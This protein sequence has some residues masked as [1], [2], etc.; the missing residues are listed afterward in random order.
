MSLVEGRRVVVS[1]K[2]AG[3]SRQTAETKLREAG[4]LVQSA[5]GK[6]TDVL[7]IGEKVG[8]TKL[9]KAKELG[10][11]VV[12]WEQAFGNYAPAAGI[13]VTVITDE[14]V[15]EGVMRPG[16]TLSSWV[17]PPRAPLPKVKQWAPMLCSPGEL[18][19]GPG[20]V[21]EM[22]WDGIRG[23]ATIEGGEV[24]LQSRS[25]KT[26]LTERY[27]VI[28]GE[29]A[30]L[31][32]CVLDGELVDGKYFVFDLLSHE[33][34]AVTHLPLMERRAILET[35]F[36]P[37]VF[38]IG[39]SPAFDDGLALLSH[40]TENGLEGLVAKRRNST[41]IEGGRG[42]E[43]IKVK[44]RREQEFVIV[45][46]TPGEGARASTFG[47]LVL[48]YYDSEGQLIYAGKVGTGFDNP[49]L[50]MLASKMEPLIRD[51]TTVESVLP[52]GLGREGI[53]LE[54]E[55]IAQVAFQKWTEDGVL[56]HPSFVRLRDDKD[57]K[58]VVRET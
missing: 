49:C 46:Y 14:G 19:S 6:D 11:D 24:M 7:V 16:Q 41:Y 28:I 53:W 9:N 8:L 58:D 22:K 15:T 55:L 40:V 2:I 36:P 47:A 21:F 38:F 50:H 39:V 54:P 25:G 44:V 29:L 32:D 3:E 26:D 57:P 1:G 30:Q 43:W 56:W 48:G 12:P 4:A 52:N 27:P 37:T 31:D 13:A 45:G 17:S 42:P 51:S 34:N 20:W 10:V 5:V 35:A 23:I 18:P 33:G